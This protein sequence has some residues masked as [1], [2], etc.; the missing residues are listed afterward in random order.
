MLYTIKKVIVGAGAI[1]VVLYAL[2][3]ITAWL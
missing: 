2:V 1:V 3:L